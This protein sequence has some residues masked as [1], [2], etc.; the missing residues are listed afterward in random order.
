MEARF[1]EVQLTDELGV[2]HFIM[3][4]GILMVPLYFVQGYLLA[5]FCGNF[6]DERLKGSRWNKGA[7]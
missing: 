1:M 3:N 6:V 2:Y 7:Q 5:Y 4:N